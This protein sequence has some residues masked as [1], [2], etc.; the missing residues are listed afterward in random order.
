L[1][2]KKR[3]EEKAREHVENLADLFETANEATLAEIRSLRNE[4]ANM[5]LV[6]AAMAEK[7]AE[8]GWLH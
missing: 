1:L 6:E 5:H 4:L 8:H 3:A 2:C 7:A